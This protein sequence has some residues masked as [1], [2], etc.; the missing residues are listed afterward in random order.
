MKEIKKLLRNIYQLLRY[1]IDILIIYILNIKKIYIEDNNKIIIVKVDA[2]GDF[3][4]WMKYA[5]E[6]RNYYKNKEIILICNEKVKEIAEEVKLFDQ[7]LTVN[8][9]LF[10]KNII[11]RIKLFKKISSLKT[12]IAIQPTYSRVAIE[13]DVLMVASNAREKISF[14]GD[15]ANDSKLNKYIADKFY[16]KLIKCNEMIVHENERHTEFINKIIGKNRN[17][18]SNIPNYFNLRKIPVNKINKYCILFISAG[19]N[20]R[21]WPLSNFIELA[22]I[23]KKN[24]KSIF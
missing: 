6:L 10:Q 2:I 7:I 4:I 12:Q 21:V 9:L 16:T 19:I 15:N 11:Y 13:G 5:A 14:Y 20:Y 18:H 23:I 1:L 8:S 3:I 22:K 17:I 24:I